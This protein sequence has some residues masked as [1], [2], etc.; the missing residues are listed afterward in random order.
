MKPWLLK[1][2]KEENKQKQ[3][4]NVA[5]LLFFYMPRQTIL[6]RKNKEKIMD[7]EIGKHL[8][9]SPPKPMK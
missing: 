8:N 4:L 9:N 6:N 2:N 7:E 5:R 3:K 1:L